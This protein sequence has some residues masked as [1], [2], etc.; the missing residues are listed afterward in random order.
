MPTLLCNALALI[1]G[2]II[3]GFIN[4][5]IIM[6]GP[7]LIPPPAGVDFNNAASLAKGI[8]LFE[9]RHFVAPFLAHALHAFAGA[10]ITYLLAASYK[11]PLALT[12]GAITLMG[13]IAASVMIPAPAWFITLDLVAA[14]MP[15]A[16]LGI[17]LGSRI[18]TGRSTGTA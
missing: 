1:A 4:M 14:Y 9:P 5:A 10:L 15:M 8:H 13:G 16:W 2:C 17:Q 7:M 18:Q 6:V 11:L 3:G 12:V